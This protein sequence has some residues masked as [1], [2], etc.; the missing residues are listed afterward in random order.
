M[1]DLPVQC[2]VFPREIKL[3]R[4]DASCNMKRFYRM[5]IERDLFGGSSL[6]REWGRIGCRGQLL[7][8][9]HGDEGQ[10]INALLKLARTKRN[11]GYGDE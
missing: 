10:A 5:T 6:I 1:F 8:E 3:K 7:V 11:R 9:R 4:I 2:E